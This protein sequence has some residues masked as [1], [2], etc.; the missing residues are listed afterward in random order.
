MREAGF[1]EDAVLAQPGIDGAQGSRIQ[2]VDAVAARPMFPNQ[3]SASEQAQMFRD[4]WPGD[5]KESSNPAGGK[6]F[7]PEEIENG[8]ARWIGECAEGSVG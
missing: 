6:P 3:T 2:L 7:L 1:P 4:G 8:P 5:G